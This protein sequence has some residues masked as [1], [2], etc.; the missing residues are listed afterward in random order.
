[1]DFEA[2]AAKFVESNAKA[3]SLRNEWSS[4]MLKAMTSDSD[5]L[6][7]GII[8]EFVDRTAEGS[9]AEAPGPP[10]ANSSVDDSGSVQLA[11]EGTSEASGERDGGE[12]L[13]RGTDGAGI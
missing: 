7:N 10:G 1:M 13:V 6:L 4:K 3:R 2:L 9:T 5:D 8:N 12:S 11:T